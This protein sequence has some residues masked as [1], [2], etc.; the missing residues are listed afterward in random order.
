[1]TI[2]QVKSIV[3]NEKN[4]EHIKKHNLE[5]GEVEE[6]IT[7]IKAYRKGYK[8]RIILIGKT[9]KRLVSVVVAKERLRRYYVVTARDADRKERKLVYEK[10]KSK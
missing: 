2:I 6:A 5:A 9:G 10:E 1:M 8:G 3:W 7:H 4:R